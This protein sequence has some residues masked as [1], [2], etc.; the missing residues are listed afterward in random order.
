VIIEVEVHKTVDVAVSIED[1]ISQI[2]ADYGPEKESDLR[3]WL[4]FVSRHYTV[5]SRLPDSMIEQMNIKQ[6]ETIAAAMEREAS[7]YR[8]FAAIDAAK[9]RTK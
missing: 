5:F 4:A 3:A 7:R 9:G 6:I 2:E 1:I 8:K